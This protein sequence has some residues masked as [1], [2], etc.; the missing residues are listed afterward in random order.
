MLG[1]LIPVQRSQ[2]DPALPPPSQKVLICRMAS[3]SWMTEMLLKLE[4]AEPSRLSV[5]FTKDP[6]WY[7]EDKGKVV[8]AGKRFK[9]HP[10]LTSMSPSLPT[11]KLRFKKK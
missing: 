3:S 2:R 1:Q 5:L 7:Y 4:G 11:K 8:L 9:G 6:P 10:V